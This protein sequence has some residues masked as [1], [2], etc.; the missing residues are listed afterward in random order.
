MKARIIVTFDCKRNCS[1]CC[2]KYTKIIKKATDLYD[3]NDIKDC[4][5]YIIT[6]GEPMLYPDKVI[7]LIKQLRLLNK[8]AKIYMYTTL[9]KPSLLK[10]IKLID[11]VHYTLHA[12]TTREDME[13]FYRF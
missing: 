13:D 8:K 10:I 6:G 1:Y 2:N 12:N 4:S 5:E 7:K 3:L 9:F 11:G